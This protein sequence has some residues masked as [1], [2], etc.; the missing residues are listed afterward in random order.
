MTPIVTSSLCSIRR[1][2]FSG[3]LLKT[4]KYQHSKR[5]EY[6]GQ[7]L[8]FGFAIWD[9]LLTRRQSWSVNRVRKYSRWLNLF[10]DYATSSS[11][12]TSTSIA[13]SIHDADDYTLSSSIQSS[14]IPISMQEVQHFPVFSC[15]CRTFC[16]LPHCRARS[17]S[18][19]MVVFTLQSTKWKQSMVPT[20]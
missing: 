11:T 19:Q 17:I 8:D 14:A 7:V 3:W 4:I 15:R 9:K 1:S 18:A 6:T 12:S 2:E 5:S 10:S 20:V 13:S 16:T